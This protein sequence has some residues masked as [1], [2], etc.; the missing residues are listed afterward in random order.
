MK[1]EHIE[2]L[3]SVLQRMKQQMISFSLMIWTTWIVM[4]KMTSLKIPSALCPHPNLLSG[5]CTHFIASD[6]LQCT[7]DEVRVSVT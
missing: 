6:I 1:W 2:I 7:A 4:L 5:D 3:I